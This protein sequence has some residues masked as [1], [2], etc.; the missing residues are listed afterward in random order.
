MSEKANDPPVEETEKKSWEQTRHG[1]YENINVS[2]RQL[3]F[4]IWGGI[5]LLV[6]VFI[7][8]GLEAAGIFYL[9]D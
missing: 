2:V 5:I 4:I 1:W 7:L 3:D 6:I 8:I 9:F